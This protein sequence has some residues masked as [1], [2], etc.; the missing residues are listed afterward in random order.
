MER[1]EK[2]DFFFPYIF[3]YRD[4]RKLLLPY[5][6]KSKEKASCLSGEMDESRYILALKM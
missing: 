4:Y 2:K 3:V 5:K 6:M 1:K